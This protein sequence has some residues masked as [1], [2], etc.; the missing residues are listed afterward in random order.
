MNKLLSLLIYKI[1][2]IITCETRVSLFE[3]Y[4]TQL[5]KM[6]GEAMFGDY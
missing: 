6:A 5:E 4:I 3:I 1:K 2:I